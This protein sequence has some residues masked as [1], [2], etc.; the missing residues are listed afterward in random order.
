M[1]HKLVHTQILSGSLKPDLNLA[2]AER[3]KALEG[4]VR[5]LAGW[6]QIGNGEHSVRKEERNKASK[7]VRMG[8]ERKVEERRVK[9]LEEVC[10]SRIHSA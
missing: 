8:L 9:S 4:R 7:E 3:R 6:A 2:P 10:L 5:E 1:L